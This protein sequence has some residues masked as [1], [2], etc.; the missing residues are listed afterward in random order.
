MRALGLLEIRGDRGAILGLLHEHNRVFTGPDGFTP[1]P[2]SE[3][4]LERLSRSYARMERPAEHTPAFLARQAQKSAMAIPPRI[5]AKDKMYATIRA[6]AE[7]GMCKADLAALH[8][9]SRTTVWRAM[10]SFK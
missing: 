6:S 10:R 8:G 1:D 3:W 7:G 2:L 4:E 5:A 9:V